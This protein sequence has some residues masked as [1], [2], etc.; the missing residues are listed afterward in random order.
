M[1]LGEDYCREG[2]GFLDYLSGVATGCP[3]NWFRLDEMKLLRTTDAVA[4]KFR[5]LQR[6]RSLFAWD[7]LGGE[8]MNFAWCWH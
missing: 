5:D 6:V 3:L 8:E 1:G 4:G 2:V 7:L